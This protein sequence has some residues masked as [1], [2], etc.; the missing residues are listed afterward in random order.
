MDSVLKSIR[1]SLSIWVGHGFKC[2]LCE[3][4]I[5][6][7]QDEHDNHYTTEV[8]MVNILFHCN[9]MKN[10]VSIRLHVII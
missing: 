5:Y 7:T 10:N 3:P 9:L 4:T 2:P 8:V 6:L 1:Q